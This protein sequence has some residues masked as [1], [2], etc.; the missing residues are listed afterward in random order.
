MNQYFL[1]VPTSL[2]GISKA[3]LYERKSDTLSIEK[4][5]HRPNMKYMKSSITVEKPA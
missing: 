5:R 1:Y 3:Y 2:F 4:I